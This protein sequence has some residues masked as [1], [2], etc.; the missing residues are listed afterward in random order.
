MKCELEVLITAFD[1]KYTLCLFAKKYKVNEYLLT[2]YM[3]FVYIMYTVG[4]T[5][6]NATK[7]NYFL[8]Y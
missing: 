2:V 6:T 5:D 1:A 4:A 8:K 3:Y 7:I